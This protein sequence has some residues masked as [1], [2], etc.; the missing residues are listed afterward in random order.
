MRVNFNADHFASQQGGL[1]V[2]FT[3]CQHHLDFWFGV[4]GLQFIGFVLAFAIGRRAEHGRS[5]WFVDPSSQ[6][7]QLAFTLTW[8]VQLPC[9]A[10]WTLLGM[11]WLADV[12]HHTPDCLAD[13]LILTPALC[14]LSQV[15]CGIFAVA[16][17]VFVFNVWDAQ[18]CRKANTLAI[19]AVQDDD[20]VHRWGPMKAA[21]NME[22]CGGLSLQE[23][24]DLPRHKV[25]CSGD[26]CVICLDTMLEDD[27]ARSLPGCG[28]VFHR[29]CV[30]LWLLRSTLCPLCNT[31]VRTHEK[32]AQ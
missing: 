22:L 26:Q 11:S 13:N 1:A 18:R 15:F 4:T 27:H 2:Q 6:V 16:Y 21:A 14:S 30:D 5:W 25:S 7:A 17:V 3:Q 24:R 12:T 32:S 28:H 19:Q 23:I 8:A 9:L 20:L 31:D 29:A 10:C